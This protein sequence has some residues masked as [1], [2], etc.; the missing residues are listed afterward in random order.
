MLLPRHWLACAGDVQ[1]L[2]WC[3][4]IDCLLHAGAVPVWTAS[5]CTL[6]H[7]QLSGCNLTGGWL[8][9]WL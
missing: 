1:R 8:V 3:Q 7:I 9:C 6:E 2:P 5:S 4:S